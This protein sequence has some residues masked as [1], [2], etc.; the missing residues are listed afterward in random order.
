ML[1][2]LDNILTHPV[3]DLP[4]N[5]VYLSVQDKDDRQRKIEGHDGGVQLIYWILGHQAQS[6]FTVSRNIL[7]GEIHFIQLLFPLLIYH[8]N[9]GCII[10]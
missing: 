6:Y 2:T 7:C 1:F 10:V 4:G 8:I 5:P 9:H 3:D